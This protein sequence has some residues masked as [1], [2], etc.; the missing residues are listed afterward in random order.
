MSQGYSANDN[1]N[2]FVQSGRTTSRV[3]QAPGGASSISLGWD[4][5]AE[6][7]K[8]KTVAPGNCE[9]VFHLTRTL[10]YHHSVTSHSA[11]LA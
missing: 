1:Q 4:D 11:N 7:S 10:S 9:W 8:E 2:Y 3:L 5:V 6:K